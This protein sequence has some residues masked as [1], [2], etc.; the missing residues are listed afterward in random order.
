MSD[1][2]QA[3]WDGYHIHEEDASGVGEERQEWVRR[4][5][6]LNFERH[7]RGPRVLEVGCGPGY[8]LQ[9]L[10]ERSFDATGTDL[11]PVN[12]ATCVEKGLDVVGVNVF[13]DRHFRRETF[14]SILMM[15]VIEHIPKDEMIVTLK[16]LRRLLKPGGT[17]VVSTQNMDSITGAHYRYMDM[18]HELGFTRE[19][20]YQLGMLV[21]DKVEV[22]PW[23]EPPP[24]PK[25]A[26]KQ[27]LVALLEGWVR[28]LWKKVWRFH[29]WMVDGPRYW[30]LFDAHGLVGV[31]TRE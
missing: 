2:R 1:P 28:P 20:M 19:S 27:P 3:Y 29:V 15:G 12:R 9:A 7:L 23:V 26:W 31:F 17:L 13:T 4:S 11:S 21:F 14:D 8:L 25:A 18:T 30:T 6:S 22:Y 24:Q 5:L 16:N 10:S